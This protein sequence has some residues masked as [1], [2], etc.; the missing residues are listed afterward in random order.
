MKT[1]PKN[2]Y[3]TPILAVSVIALSLT[4]CGKSNNEKVMEALAKYKKANTEYLSVLVDVGN[5]KL[6]K[7]KEAEAEA[8]FQK[9]IIECDAVIEKYGTPDQKF[10]APS[11]NILKMPGTME[12]K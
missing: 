7:E 3:I 9:V 8:K 2:K 1:K 4:A 5:R 11:T 12:F 10:W 6:P